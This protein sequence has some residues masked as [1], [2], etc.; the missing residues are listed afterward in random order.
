MPP[1]S[2]WRSGLSPSRFWKNEETKWKGQNLGGFP[3]ERNPGA[4]SVEVTWIGCTGLHFVPT[5]V[6][7]MMV[8]VA[9]Q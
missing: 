9:I 1:A 2:L 5:R 7:R 8:G 4:Y 3:V 6:E